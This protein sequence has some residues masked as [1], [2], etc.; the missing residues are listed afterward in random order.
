MDLFVLSDKNSLASQLISDMRDV[1]VQAD[2]LRFRRNLERIGEILAYEISKTFP[3]RKE[4]VTTPLGTKEV[5]I[6]AQQP[7]LA[8]ILRAGVPFFQGM[9]NMFDRADCAFAGAYRGA[10]KADETFD[11][12]MEY[13]SSPSI[14]GRILI[15]ADPML[16]TGKSLVKSYKALLQKGT[17][18]Q[19]HFVSVIAAREGIKYVS[20]AVPEASIWC[21]AVDEQLNHKFYIM[22]GLGDAGDLAYGSKL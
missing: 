5:H 16:A 3:Y 9:L 20:A 4:T 11:I 15:I 22:P 1:T 21:A 17:P 8:T 10:H 2:R 19:V 13:L 7:V 18:L 14:E 6:P 12:E